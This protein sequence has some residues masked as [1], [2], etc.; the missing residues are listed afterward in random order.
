MDGRL[1]ENKRLTSDL[2]PF[3]LG[4]AHACPHA[5]DDEAA[6][7]FSDGPDDDYNGPAQRSAGVD[8]FAEAD[9]LDVQPVQ[10]VQDFEEV[11]NRP[12]DPVRSP[13][14][15]DIEATAAGIVHQLV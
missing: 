1:I 10:L 9:E 4:A 13:D 5:L 8:L 15:D 7:Q 14:Q 11:L 2:A 6:L 12:G 3:E